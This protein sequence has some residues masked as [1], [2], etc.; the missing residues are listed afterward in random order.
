MSPSRLIAL[1][2]FPLTPTG[3]TDRT[4]LLQW[5]SAPRETPRSKDAAAAAATTPTEARLIALWREMLGLQ[6]IA[7]NDDFFELG[8]HSL[9]A[10]RMVTEIGR[11]FGRSLRLTDILRAPTIRQLANALDR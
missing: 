9:M 3:K 4:R 8:G 6:D 10:T 11:R 5:A 1:D 7:P 2:A